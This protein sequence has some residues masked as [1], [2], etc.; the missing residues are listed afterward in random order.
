MSDRDQTQGSV[1]PKAG[2][3]YMPGY[4]I[5]DAD[6]GSG[7]RPW[8][9]TTERL[10]KARNY[11]IATTR[12]D[13]RP[14]AMPIWGVWFENKFYFSTGRQSRKARNLMD[15][16]SCVVCAEQADDAVIV[17]GRVEEVSDQALLRR[18]AE[19][20]GAKYHWE[21]EGF[22]EPVYVVVPTVAFAFSSAPGEF[23]GSATRWRFGR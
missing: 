4:G 15:N 6:S 13:G 17:E 5:L 20:Y 21:M 1:E 11:W 14:H 7:L 18:F 2:R 10:E 9:W 8:S 22:A 16:P 3:P 19:I 23:A 12:P